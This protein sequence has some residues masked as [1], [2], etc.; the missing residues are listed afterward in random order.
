M[1]EKKVEKWK[2]PRAC[3]ITNYSTWLISW[4]RRR[5]ARRRIQPRMMD[6]FSA[7]SFITTLSHSASLMFIHKVEFDCSVALVENH[8]SLMMIL[9]FDLFW[10][11]WRIWGNWGCE[12]ASLLRHVTSPDEA[13]Q[14]RTWSRWKHVIRSQIDHLL[15]RTTKEAFFIIQQCSGSLY[16]IHFCFTFF[17]KLWRAW[18]RIFRAN[19][20]S[21]IFLDREK[22]IKN[23]INQ[24]CE[25][26]I[27]WLMRSK[28]ETIIMESVW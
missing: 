8:R 25:M 4:K 7:R 21:R 27:S 15:S 17:V 18:N 26:I 1:R 24:F 10:L 6:Q 23:K 20:L 22:D 19:M 16:V 2:I 12:W 13:F 11:S 14:L 3:G 9:L 28:I 5:V